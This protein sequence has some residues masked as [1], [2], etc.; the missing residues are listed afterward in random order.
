MQKEKT[1]D[2]FKYFIV[3]LD[4]VTL[5]MVLESLE[6]ID[7]NLNNINNID[8]EV[9]LWKTKGYLSC[10]QDIRKNIELW[11]EAKEVG[12]EQYFQE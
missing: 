2:D 10:L 6:P 3:S 7:K 9:T 8:S 5:K 1:M 11:I 4:I 12:V